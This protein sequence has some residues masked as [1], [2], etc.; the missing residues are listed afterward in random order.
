[1]SVKVINFTQAI[2]DALPLPPKGKRAYYKDQV[3]TGLTLDVKSSGSKSYYLYKKINGRPERIFLGLYPDLKI[4]EARRMALIKKG[5]IAKGINP[6]DE[7]RKVRDEMDFETLFNEYLERYS[8]IHKKSWQYDQREIKKYLGHWF[9][10]KISNIK[11]HEIQ[12]LHEQLRADSGLYQA[13]RILERLRAIYNK[14]IEWGWEGQNPAIGI[15]KF[16]EKSRDRFVQPSELPLLFAALEEEENQTAKDFILMSFMTGAR[17]TNVLM[18]RWEQIDFQHH[19]WRIP[20]TKNGDSVSIPLIAPAIEILETRKKKTKGDWVFEGEG[21]SGYFA[22]PKKAWDRIRHK[23]T[24]TLWRQNPELDNL[25]TA[26]ENKIKEKGG[27]VYTSLKLITEV[28]KAAK[29]QK[30]DLPTGLLDLRMHD[31]RRTL[32]SYQA[33]TG[34]SLPIIGK[35]LGHKNS[36]STAIYA[37]LN[38]DPVRASMDK[39]T[40][41]IFGFMKKVA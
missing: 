5:Q 20:E 14:A 29:S 27:Y 23:A 21:N 9:K 38:L 41:A 3:E 13:N 18:M 1:M 25:I 33:I 8:K 36:Q 35:T 26:V 17:K 30:I 4:P 22:D 34:A 37:R 19:I 39:A 12:K 31:I 28:E 2:I 40:E 32:G 10:R 7:K 11:K 16:K 6:Q 15:K 24:L